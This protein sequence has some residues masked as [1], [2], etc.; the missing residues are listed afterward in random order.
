[1]GDE[2]DLSESRGDLQ[3]SFS[4]APGHWLHCSRCRDGSRSVEPEHDTHLFIT[5]H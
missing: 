5:S 3:V 2:D 1:M 4:L